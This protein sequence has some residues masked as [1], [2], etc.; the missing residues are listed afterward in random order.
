MSRLFESGWGL[1]VI[2]LCIYL[3]VP[4]SPGDMKNVKS[5]FSIFD[6]L[7]VVASPTSFYRLSP[8]SPR[9]QL[10]MARLQHVLRGWKTFHLPYKLDLCHTEYI[11][12]IVATTLSCIAFYIDSK[13][14]M[15]GSTE[16]PGV[17][18]LMGSED[19]LDEPEKSA[20]EKYTLRWEHKTLWLLHIISATGGLWITAG[21]W[22]VLVGDDVI[23]ANNITKHLLNSVFMLIDTCLSCIPVRLVHWLYALLYF[24]V[25]IAFSLI[26]W[27]LGGTNIEGKPYI[28]KALDYNDFSPIFGGLLVVFLLVVLPFLHLFLLGLTKLRDYIHKKPDNDKSI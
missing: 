20:R 13:K 7:S 8:H 27:Q 25:Y 16:K 10:G 2:Y 28:Y 22:T 24:A 23:D 19:E 17:E 11:Y 5:I 26:Y 1:N 18:I 4:R 6:F 14:Q 21:Y 15:E 3:L 9:L 12:F